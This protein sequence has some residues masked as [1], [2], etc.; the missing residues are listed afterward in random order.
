M[1]MKAK[2]EKLDTE[3]RNQILNSSRET[4]FREQEKVRNYL[5]VPLGPIGWDKPSKQPGPV[6]RSKERNILQM[7]IYISTAAVSEDNGSDLVLLTD[8]KATILRVC[9]RET[10]LK[11][12]EDQ[13][14]RATD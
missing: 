7:P 1:N 12:L 10:N 14:N 13:K 9:S 4:L 6:E 11:K 3:R 2:F 8:L 5:L